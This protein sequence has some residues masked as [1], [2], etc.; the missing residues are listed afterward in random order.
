MTNHHR[1]TIRAVDLL[2]RRVLGWIE[3]LPREDPADALGHL[4]GL[5]EVL[6]RVQH[7]LVILDGNKEGEMGVVSVLQQIERAKE[8]ECGARRTLHSI[9]RTISAA[10]GELL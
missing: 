1:L 7:I 4:E 8:M 6:A 3:D 5:S 9:C 10:G 2:E